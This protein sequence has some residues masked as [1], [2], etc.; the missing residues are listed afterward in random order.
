MA[1]HILVNPD[2]I[3]STTFEKAFLDVAGEPASAEV[4]FTVYGI[5]APSARTAK[6]SSS[7]SSGRVTRRRRSSGSA[8][9]ARSGSSWRGHRCRS[10]T[11]E[12]Q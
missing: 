10:S 5:D 2:V 1:T 3:T 9:P 6:V 8:T 7:T 12:D 11:P 4:T